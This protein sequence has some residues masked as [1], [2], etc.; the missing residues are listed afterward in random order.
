VHVMDVPDTFNSIVYATVQPSSFDNLEENFLLLREQKTHPLLLTAI[1]R[2]LANQRLTPT[3]GVLLTDE[4][5][6]VEWIVN[7]MVLNYVISGN[8]EELQ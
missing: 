5:A 3:V 4:R 7:S 8:Y 2:T 6:P 1:E